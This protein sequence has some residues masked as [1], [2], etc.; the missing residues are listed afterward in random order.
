[1]QKRAITSRI[2]IAVITTIFTLS[3]TLM[4][5]PTVTFAAELNDGVAFSAKITTTDGMKVVS[6]GQNNVSLKDDA[7]TADQVWQ[8][9]Y[10]EVKGTYALTSKAT[11]QLL[12]VA[13]DQNNASVQATTANNT[14]GQRQRDRKSVV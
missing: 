7:N 14:S 5:V 4:M 3:L 12:T 9:V 1:M 2:A 10:N 13:S 6:A 8:F 11:G